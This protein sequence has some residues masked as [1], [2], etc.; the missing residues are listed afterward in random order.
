MRWK[1]AASWDR[2]PGE[3]TLA[4]AGRVRTGRMGTLVPPLPKRWTMAAL[5]VMPSPPGT[6]NCLE[7]ALLARCAEVSPTTVRMSQ[8][9]M[10][11]SLWARTQRVKVDIYLL[12]FSFFGFLGPPYAEIRTS[13]SHVHHLFRMTFVIPPPFLVLS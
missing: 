1:A 11:M 7:R 3:S 6:V 9:G 12:L 13:S 4:P 8:K 5:V 2:T 10:T